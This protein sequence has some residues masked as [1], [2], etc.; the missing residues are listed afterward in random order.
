MKRLLIGLSLLAASHAQLN[1][2]EKYAESVNVILSSMESNKGSI[3]CNQ[4]PELFCGKGCSVDDDV[5]SVVGGNGDFCLSMGTPNCID[6]IFL[7]ESE[8]YRPFYEIQQDNQ[9]SDLEWTQGSFWSSI[10]TEQ[11]FMFDRCP[12]VTLFIETASADDDKSDIED[13]LNDNTHQTTWVRYAY[14]KDGKGVTD[15]LLE[16]EFDTLVVELVSEEN[17]HLLVDAIDLIDATTNLVI[18]APGHDLKTNKAWVSSDGVIAINTRSIEV[19]L[20]N[21]LSSSATVIESRIWGNSSVNINSTITDIYSGLPFT[22]NFESITYET[23]IV[24]A[25]LLRNKVAPNFII[26]GGG[27]YSFDFIAALPDDELLVTLA[28]VTSTLEVSLSGIYGNISQSTLE[29]L[30]DVD[31]NLSIT[32]MLKA[33][34]SCDSSFCGSDLLKPIYN[35]GELPINAPY[36]QCLYEPDSDIVKRSYDDNSRCEFTEGVYTGECRIIADNEDEEAATDI[37]N[38]YGIDIEIIEV[39][40]TSYHVNTA[41]DAIDVQH[42]T[43]SVY[44]NK[45]NTCYLLKAIIDTSVHETGEVTDLMTAI[46][47]SAVLDNHGRFIEIIVKLSNDLTTFADVTKSSYD[48][49]TF[50]HYDMQFSGASVNVTGWCPSNMHTVSMKFQ[51]DTTLAPQMFKHIEDNI[52]YNNL[53]LL[54]LE[55]INTDSTTISYMIDQLTSPFLESVSIVKSNVLFRPLGYQPEDEVTFTQPLP[56]NIDRYRTLRYVEIIDTNLNFF[57]A[58]IIAPQLQTLILVNAFTSG[59]NITLPE[60]LGTWLPQLSNLVLMDNM[61]LQGEVPISLLQREYTESFVLSG[62]MLTGT[63][64][65]SYDICRIREGFTC[66]LP[67]T[68][69]IVGTCGCTTVPFET[70]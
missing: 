35:N 18:Y 26:L 46:G 51:Q 68:I 60:Q 28:E 25:G 49:N 64:L 38:Y 32:G 66:Q 42:I 5:T 2:P 62:S 47:E 59:V 15:R 53:A 58:S 70:K 44:S 1:F 69:T 54:H 29:N 21:K 31:Y 57:P 20:V 4:M 11:R 24:S 27:M 67:P 10:F 45:Y 3:R 55:N 13:M 16:F 6:Q 19:P 17:T 41:F 48:I 61:G 22:L 8:Q 30:V 56:D 52:D 37:S 39:P 33:R 12:F 43:H 65:S 7:L 36:V 23:T 9:F 40:D 14:G 50:Y 34:V 63:V